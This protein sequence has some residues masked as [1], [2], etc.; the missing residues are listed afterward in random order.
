LLTKGVKGIFPLPAEHWKKNR[1]VNLREWAQRS[2][3]QQIDNPPQAFEGWRLRPE[4][5]QDAMR[6]QTLAAGK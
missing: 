3:S 2:S 5:G 1:R 6:Q 4:G